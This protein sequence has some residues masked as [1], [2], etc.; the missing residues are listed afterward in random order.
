M[1]KSVSGQANARRFS[2]GQLMVAGL[3]MLIIAFLVIGTMNEAATPA[4]ESALESNPNHSWSW[5]F[6]RCLAAC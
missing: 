1:E 2:T 4:P 5:L 3:V 6:S